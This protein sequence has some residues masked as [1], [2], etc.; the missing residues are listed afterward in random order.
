VSSTEPTKVIEEDDPANEPTVNISIAEAQKRAQAAADAMAQRDAAAKQQAAADAQAAEDDAQRKADEARVRDQERQARAKALGTVAVSDDDVE[1]AP[2]E[3]HPNDKFLGSLGL[4]LIRIVLVALLGVRG[5]QVVSHIGATEDWLTNYHIP[6]PT[7]VAWLLGAVLIIV[8]LLLLVGFG[9]R[10]AGL[11]TAAV[12][13]LVL[14]FIR[15]GYAP[16]LV[17]GQAGFVGD[18][19]VVVAGV[20]LA[21]F[22]LG[23]GGWAIDAA[24]RFNRAKRKQY[25]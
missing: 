2:P 3:R 19:D 18:W 21:V 15:W 16:V 12:A 17:S 8:A 5:V 4:F 25:Q 22:C 9:T 20:G 10:L 14:V 7:L 24:M 23:S 6:Q 11:L 13:V 1:V